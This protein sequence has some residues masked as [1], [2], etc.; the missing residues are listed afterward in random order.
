MFWVPRLQSVIAVQ[1]RILTSLKELKEK[2]IW[3]N[4]WFVIIPIHYLVLDA[5]VEI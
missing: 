3:K 1:S 2:L 4:V 5:E